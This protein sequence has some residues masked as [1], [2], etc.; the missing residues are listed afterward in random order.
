MILC[1]FWGQESTRTNFI[2]FLPLFLSLFLL[3][4]KWAAL[5]KSNFPS[6]AYSVLFGFSRE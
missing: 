2:E 1:V 5:N 6:F 4:L 3:L